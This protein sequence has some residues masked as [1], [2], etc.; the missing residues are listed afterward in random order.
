MKEKQ[1]NYIK[2]CMKITRETFTLKL[3]TYTLA[4][5]SPDLVEKEQTN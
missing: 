1:M 5:V 2:I 3:E 4:L